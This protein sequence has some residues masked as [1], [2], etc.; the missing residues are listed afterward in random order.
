M[1]A[2]QGLIGLLLYL[3]PFIL[4][5]LRSRNA[6][7]RMP[8]LGFL[9][10]NM[11]LSMWLVILAFFVVQNLAPMVVVFGLGLNWITLGLIS[12]YVYLYNS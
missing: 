2:E 4:L 9:N 3:I 5:F 8:K 11:L 6:L 7:S 1:L 12:N 10:Q